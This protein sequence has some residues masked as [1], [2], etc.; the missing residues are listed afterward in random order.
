MSD[1]SGEALPV[2]ELQHPVLRTAY[3]YWCL[4]KGERE[5]PARADITPE[6]MKLYLSRVMLVDV[7]YEPL[8]FV[9]RVF[10]SGIA[11]AFGKD[12]SGKSVRQ[13]EPPEFA[14]LIWR[15]YL[16][17]VNERRPCLH[18]IQVTAGTRFL[19]YHRLT[20]PLSADGLAVDKLLAISI[21]D[22]KFWQSLRDAE[23]APPNRTGTAG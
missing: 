23:P 16:E 21:E 20:L 5:F 17:V 11:Q 4:I 3:D 12:Y 9:Y 18:A 8:D 14:A 19:K 15:Q 1:F 22:G 7:S 6:G 2:T 10:G 13:L